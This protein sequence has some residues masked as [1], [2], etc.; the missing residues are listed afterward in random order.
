M[1]RLRARIAMRVVESKTTQALLTTFN[2]VD[3]SAVI[4]TRSRYEDAFELAHGP[5]LDFMSF[6]V[7]AS[8]RALRAYP[9]INAYVDGADIVY[10]TYYDVSVAVATDRGLIVPVL[11]DAD[12]M[13]LVDIERAIAS[14]LT[15]AREGTITVEDLTGGNLSITNGGEFGS[16]MSTPVV[17]APQSATLGMHKVLNRPVVVGD[18]IA[19]RPMMYLALCYDHRII[20]GREAVKFLVMIKESIEDP[21]RLLLDV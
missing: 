21:A 20:D 5:R 19:V 10:R 12:L 18:A 15:K 16:F 14:Y 11:R 3:M 1:S 7:R 9:I 4:A 17:N 6:F 8:V 2:E 13:S